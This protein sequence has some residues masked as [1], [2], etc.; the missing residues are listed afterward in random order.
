MLHECAYKGRKESNNKYLVHLFVNSLM[1][2]VSF[3]SKESEILMLKRRRGE[4]RPK[5]LIYNRDQNG[6]ENKINAYIVLNSR[7]AMTSMIQR[8][9]CYFPVII[10]P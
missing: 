10:F 9:S 5:K 7:H 8:Q 3:S 2:A 4:G 6:R 1:I